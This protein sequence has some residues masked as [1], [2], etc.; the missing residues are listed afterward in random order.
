METHP[1][2][3]ASLEAL[4]RDFGASGKPEELHQNT[5]KKGELFC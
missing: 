2:C 1:E 4:E 3:E 5:D